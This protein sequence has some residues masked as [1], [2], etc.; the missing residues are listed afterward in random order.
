MPSF[1]EGDVFAID[2]PLQGPFHLSLSPT[3]VRFWMW[4]LFQVEKRAPDVQQPHR[5][6]GVTYRVARTSGACFCGAT[7]VFFSNSMTRAPGGNASRPGQT[8]GRTGER[9]VFD[10]RNA[11]RRDTSRDT[12]PGTQAPPPGSVHTHGRRVSVFEPCT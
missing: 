8:L 4:H 1:V 2:S 3:Y 6:D 7:L 11:V 9:D 12:A 5:D 10:G